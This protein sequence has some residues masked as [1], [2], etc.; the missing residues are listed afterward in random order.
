MMGKIVEQLCN[1]LEE[2]RKLEEQIA[3]LGVSPNTLSVNSFLEVFI[4]GEHSTLN[5]YVF[6]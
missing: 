5:L 6:V 1:A 3:S 4:C 2:M